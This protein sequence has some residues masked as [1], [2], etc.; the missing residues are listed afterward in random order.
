M[1]Q[2]EILGVKETVAY[3]ISNLIGAGIL[4]VP[5]IAYSVGGVYVFAIWL[6]LI[7]AS[8]PLAKVFAIISIRYPHNSGILHFLHLKAS[9]GIS[10][11]VDDVMIFVMLVGNPTL[12]FVASRYA[13]SAFG[14]DGDIFFY[15][16][17]FFF[18]AFSV[19]FNMLGLR[20]S[21]RLQFILTFV[22]LFVLLSI[23]TLATYW[24]IDNTQ[25]VLQPSTAT[26]FVSIETLLQT[27]GICFF[28]F[29]GWEN[30]AAIAPNVKE[31][32]RT[33]NKSILISVPLVGACYLF[34]AFALALSATQTEAKAN[35]AVL[36]LMTAPFKGGFLPVLVSL[37]SIFIVV[38]SCNA[39]VLAASKVL[40]GLSL[41][42]RL[43]KFLSKETNGTPYIALIVL[44][45][46][47]GL[48]ILMSYLFGNQEDLIIRYSSAG[49]I[50][51]YII[52]Q[53]YFFKL[54]KAR[55]ERFLA[56]VGLIFTLLAASG[57]Y[58]EVM[59]WIVMGFALWAIRQFRVR[60]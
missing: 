48:V 52:V 2:T 34:I 50:T 9:K 3:Y 33:F 55:K 6:L 29:V 20:S 53:W 42:G 36:D 56:L 18:M 32:A 4:V 28:V 24:N 43:P 16:L 15:P 17:A 58:F 5:A 12:G 30:V 31:R 59:L 11:F 38:V 10:Q 21:S 27:L 54:E 41:S 44:L 26:E 47:Y 22:M 25:L 60:R 39:W 45:F 13:I 51:I 46:C 8:W 23:A 19:M 1:K 35:F 37:F 57:L 14:L 7:I 49:F 40:N